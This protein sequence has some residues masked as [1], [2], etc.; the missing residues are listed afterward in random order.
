MPRKV[1]G[2]KIV[3]PDLIRAYTEEEIV[4]LVKCKRDILHF[5]RKYI[6]IPTPAFGLIDMEPYDYQIELLNLCDSQRFIII[7]APR[8]VGKSTTIALYALW[9]ACFNDHRTIAIVSNREA[10][11]KTILRRMQI[12]YENLPAFLKPGSRE[13]A[14]TG[15]TFDNETNVIVGPTTE[16]SITG[17]SV[18]VLICDE[19]AKVKPHVAED[20]WTSNYPTISAGGQIICISTPKGIGNLFHRLWVKALR[21]MNEFVPFRV[22]W[23]EVPGRDEAWMNQEVNNLGQRKFDQEY[24]LKFLGSANTLIRGDVLEKI[25]TKFIEPIGYRDGERARIYEYPKPGHTYV[26][27]VD[28]SKGMEQDDSVIQIFDITKYP[29]KVNQVFT[30][31]SNEISIWD[32][33]TLVH[34]YAIWY[35]DAYIMAENNA[36]GYSVLKDLWFDL[37]YENLVN[38]GQMDKTIQKKK[39]FDLGIRCT[40]ATKPTANTWLKKMVEDGTLDLVDG[41]TINQLCDYIEDRGKFYGESGLDDHVSSLVW[42]CYFFKTKFFD[43]SDIKK[44]LQNPDHQSLPE[45]DWDAWGI[46]TD[47]Y[48]SDIE[49]TRQEFIKEL[50]KP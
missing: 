9:Y 30:F 38:V 16:D 12:M 13:W 43:E 24:G 47:D 3:G 8:Q 26:M 46:Q 23:W 40:Q 11:A 32:F 2:E 37:E 28:I 33:P 5:S 20:F 17:E 18:A 14:K 6:K 22:D 10:S 48:L 25:S 50:M 29:E 42:A 21:E 44:R 45:D 41:F 1:D 34:K 7:L 19:L 49:R 36:E 27:G 35:N 31:S 4:E 39:K 15:V